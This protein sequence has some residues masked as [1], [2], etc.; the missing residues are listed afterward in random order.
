MQNNASD[1]MLRQ[2]QLNQSTTIQQNECNDLRNQLDYLS[3]QNRL[4]TQ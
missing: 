2:S 4:L 3:N 1:L